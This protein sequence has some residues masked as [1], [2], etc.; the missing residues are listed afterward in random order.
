M[1]NLLIK[2]ATL[3]ND[4]IQE[5]KAQRPRLFWLAIT[6]IAIANRKKKLFRKRN[7]AHLSVLGVT[8]PFS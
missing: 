1:S 3:V 7:F 4:G 6:Y 2:N 5:K 8:T